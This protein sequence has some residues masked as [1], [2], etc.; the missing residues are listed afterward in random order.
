[1]AA[2]EAEAGAELLAG[3]AGL[4]AWA[5][6]EAMGAGGGAAA[7]HAVAAGAAGEHEGAGRLRGALVSFLG[8]LCAAARARAG[9]AALLVRGGAAGVVVHALGVACGASRPEDAA[10][11]AAARGECISLWAAVA[12]AAAAAARCLAVDCAAH[13]DMHSP[14]AVDCAA[15]PLAG[16]GP[17]GAL[18]S[19]PVQE[20]QEALLAAVPHLLA[21]LEP[22]AAD[23]HV[24]SRAG[25]PSRAVWDIAVSAALALAALCVRNERAAA[26][27]AAGGALP[28]ALRLLAGDEPAAVLHQAAVDLVVVMGGGAVPR[29]VP[30]RD[31]TRAGVLSAPL[32]ALACSDHPAVALVAMRAIA[33]PPS[34]ECCVMWAWLPEA[35]SRLASA[36][37]SAL[38]SRDPALAAAAVGATIAVLRVTWQLPVM[39]R[40]G[41]DAFVEAGVAAALG[42]LLLEAPTAGAGASSADLR[43]AAAGALHTACRERVGSFVKAVASQA[44]RGLVAAMRREG[45]PAGEA[46]VRALKEVRRHPV[47]RAACLSPEDDERLTLAAF[48]LDRGRRYHT[49]RQRDAALTARGVGW[50]AAR[51]VAPEYLRLVRVDLCDNARVGDEGASALCSLLRGPGGLRSLL[52]RN[53]GIG[54]AGAVALAGALASNTALRELSLGG[55]GAAGGVGC[56]NSVGVTGLVALLTSLAPNLSLRALWLPGPKPRPLSLRAEDVLVC[57]IYA[58]IFSRFRACPRVRCVVHVRALCLSG[59]A[60][61]QRAGTVV[62]WLASM[63]PLWVVVRV[64]ALLAYRVR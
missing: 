12:A 47:A 42:E 40:A 41:E 46:A 14:L 23:V 27:V 57:R 10:A 8:A 63:A 38:R 29:A 33:R 53:C 6:I 16:S 37:A 52:L 9:N 28:T 43:T 19:E 62:G 21:L 30:P 32:A 2:S 20:A 5:F 13:R 4:P 17:D 44:G 1:M 24:W 61:P 45:D 35:G 56:R 64:S 60:V 48:T 3:M 34:A 26:A 11:A 7:A 58:A 51:L 59:R 55:R 22:A 18:G 25:A 31:G 15:S 54:D 39:S 36:L 50:L 49:F